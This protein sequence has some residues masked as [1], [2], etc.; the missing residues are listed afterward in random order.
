MRQSS[1]FVYGILS[2]MNWINAEMT[3]QP[4]DSKE[5]QKI[6]SKIILLFFSAGILKTEKATINN[7]KQLVSN[8]KLMA[9]FP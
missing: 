9:M 3:I 4:I 2:T 8:V 5:R 6:L 1:F 7:P